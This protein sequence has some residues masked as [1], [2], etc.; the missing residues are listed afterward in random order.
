MLHSHL[1]IE[2]IDQG[3]DAIQLHLVKGDYS[4]EQF[5]VLKSRNFDWNTMHIDFAVLGESHL[6][7]IKKYNDLFTEICACSP[8]LFPKAQ[9]VILSNQLTKITNTPLKYDSPYFLYAFDS[10][11]TNYQY[12]KKK[13]KQ[14]RERNKETEHALVFFFPRHSFFSEKAVTEV[15]IQKSPTNLT[16]ETVH[17][18]PNAKQMVFT[19]SSIVL[20]N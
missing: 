20:K 2:Y 3:I 16:I 5:S 9:E 4:L 7:S 13:L 14:M 18:Y 8:V 12:G 17:T 6:V 11:S 10:E 15:Y 19:K 1:K